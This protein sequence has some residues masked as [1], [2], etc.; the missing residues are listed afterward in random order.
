MQKRT[1]KKETRYTIKNIE[2]H[3]SLSH[4][5]EE[6]AS[7]H[8]NLSLEDKKSIAKVLSLNLGVLLF[9]ISFMLWRGKTGRSDLEKYIAAFTFPMSLFICKLS[10]YRSWFYLQDKLSDIFNYKNRKEKYSDNNG[11]IDDE[12]RINGS[13]NI[14]W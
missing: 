8:Y 6:S 10:I 12:N 4:I 1:N 2:K 11:G 7:K 14:R 5:Y 9:N 3:G 13:H